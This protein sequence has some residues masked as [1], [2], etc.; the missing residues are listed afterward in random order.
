[1]ALFNSEFDLWTPEGSVSFGSIQFWVCSTDSRRFCEFWFCLILNLLN[2]L[3]KVLY[4]LVLFYSEFF[5]HKLMK[6]L[7][8]LIPCNSEFVPQ[9]HE[10]SVSSGSV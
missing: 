8:V 2:E 5:P 3:Q 1:M 6:F 10:G 9:T 7:W 4:V